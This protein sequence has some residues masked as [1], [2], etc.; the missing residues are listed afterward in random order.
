[1]GNELTTSSE[2]T[3]QNSFEIQELKFQNFVEDI[4]FK[5]HSPINITMEDIG[6]PVPA[7]PL[8][9]FLRNSEIQRKSCILSLIVEKNAPFSNL[10]ILPDETSVQRNSKDIRVIKDSNWVYTV[11]QKTE[12]L[13]LVGTF[14]YK[15]KNEDFAMYDQLYDFVSFH[16]FKFVIKDA[17]PGKF[18]LFVIRKKPNFYFKEKETL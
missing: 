1:M 11:D 9:E 12:A 14:P 2:E 15:C 10:L 8:P 13:D 5:N 6:T 4:S 17:P 3:F 7:T 18:S 16:G